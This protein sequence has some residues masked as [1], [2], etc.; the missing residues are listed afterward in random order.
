VAPLGVINQTQMA[1][2]LLSLGILNFGVGPFD[3]WLRHNDELV[4]GDIL[5]HLNQ[6]SPQHDCRNY[7]VALGGVRMMNRFSFLSMAILILSFCSVIP[8]A[9]AGTNGPSTANLWV[10]TSG[11]T[12]TRQATAGPYVDAQACSSMSAAFSAASAGD[13]IVIKN[14]TYG[15]QSLSGTAKA[16]AVTF[17]AETYQSV[18]V[19]GLSISVDKVNV[20]GVIGSGTG[21]SRGRLDLTSTGT[22]VLV[23]GFRGSSIFIS[24]N[25]ITVQNGEFGNNNTDLVNGEFDCVQV[26][27]GASDITLKNNTFH[28]H[29]QNSTNNDIT[30]HNDMIQF[31]PGGSNITIDGNTFYNGPTS[32]IQA[33][34]GTL[35]NWIV[36]NNYFGDPVDGG[37]MLAWGQA[38]MGSLIFRNNVIGGS[39]SFINNESGGTINI[40]GNIYL[41]SVAAC[42]VQGSP[43][44]G[45]NIFPV[46][47]GVT[48]GSNAR[49][50]SPTWLNGKP[51]GSN[52]Y[53]IRLAA[54][55]TCAIDHGN[56]SS[57]PSADSYGN[58]RYAGSA[59][60]AGAFEF[61]ISGVSTPK[62][63]TNLHITSP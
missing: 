42:T 4:F 6:V 16:S 21:N 7:K 26:W 58:A 25:H 56:P 22:G 24:G 1:P 57:Y 51:S 46:S 30:Y 12:C 18:L 63:P 17:Y 14:G 31:Y 45:Y 8:P 39:I 32:N 54:S 55:D 48:C 37:N 49:R 3:R 29:H 44:G 23:D 43:S 33:G 61:G 11:G 52:N 47:G 19:G 2:F 38:T 5:I 50:C 10:D 35:N 15:S 62:V 13:T 53:D 41:S 28:D 34:G 20:Y 59:P 60:D 40:S 27:N 9:Q 36:Q